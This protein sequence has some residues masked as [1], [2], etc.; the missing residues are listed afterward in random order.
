[1]AGQ[2]VAIGVDINKS[3]SSFFDR[4]LIRRLL[5]P[6]ERRV[7]SRFGAFVR[8]RARQS[9]RFRKKAVSRAGNPPFSHTKDPVASIKNIL[10]SFDAFRKSV[11][12]GPVK[13]NQ[14]QFSSGVLTT[15]TVPSV[16]EYGGTVGIREKQRTPGGK[17]GPIGRRRILRPG[18]RLR[19]RQVSYD[20][21]PFM[22]PAFDYEI[23]NS[24][25]KIWR[26][27]LSKRAA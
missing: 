9:I 18:E 10:F 15:G 13:L 19:V 21:R 22:Q 2:E 24:L 25:P 12:I 20:P 17:W 7:L 5:T 11:V 8:K 1:M 3:K 23:K 27:A 16:L 26:D 6:V 4:D 14:K